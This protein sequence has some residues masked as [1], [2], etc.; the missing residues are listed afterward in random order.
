VEVDS[1]DG[2]SLF[3]RRNF[4]KRR[5]RRYDTIPRER[6]ISYDVLQ[7]LAHAILGRI[8]PKNNN[9]TGRRLQIT[10]KS[11]LVTSAAK[12]VSAAIERSRDYVML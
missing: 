4:G 6:T 1:R 2:I 8:K 12:K 11:G 10:W 7:R 5:S 3:V 9:Y